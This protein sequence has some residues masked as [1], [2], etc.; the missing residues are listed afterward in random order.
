MN[1]EHRHSI[2]LK[3]IESEKIARQDQIVTK[4]AERGFDVTQASVS[5]DLVELGV[6]KV[7]GQYTS[8]RHGESTDF[9][10]IGLRA[11]GDNLIVVNCQSGLASAIAVKMDR[12][13][14]SEIVGT[15]AGDDTIF[16]AVESLQHQRIVI[17][18]LWDVLSR[19]FA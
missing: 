12:A 8:P 6:V 11:A 18:K 4:L 10:P 15:I 19:K 14:I 16:V 13:K 1:R 7:G 9:G 5:R 3:M 17:K 2:I